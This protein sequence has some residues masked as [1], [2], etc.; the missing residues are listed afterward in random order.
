MSKAKKPIA[1]TMKPDKTV[2]GL[3]VRTMKATGVSS[4]VFDGRVAGVKRRWTIGRVDNWKLKAAQVEARRLATDYDKGI[5]PKAVREAEDAAA[6]AKRIEGQRHTHTV[7]PIWAVYIADRKDAYDPKKRK[8]AWGDRHY[9]MHL[10]LAAPGGEKKKKRGGKGKTIPGPLAPLMKLKLSELTPDTVEHWL[11]SEVK[12]RP[13]NAHQSYRLLSAFVKW[14]HSYKVGKERPYRGIVPADACTD[15]DVVKQVPSSN[16]RK[17]DCLQRDDLRKWFGGVQSIQNPIIRTYLQVLLLI[18]SRRNEL[19][20]LKWS[21]VD[22]ARGEMTIRDKVE[23]LRKIPLTP[24][25]AQLLTALPRST[26]A[27]CKHWVFW[28]E[29]SKTGHIMEPRIAHNDALESAGLPHVSLHGLRRS[30][31]TLSDWDGLDFPAGVIAQIQGHKASGVRET[32]Y[33]RREVDQLRVWHTKFE[34]W[35]LQQGGI[36][37]APLAA[38]RRLGLVNTDGR[39]RAAV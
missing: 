36:K 11:K 13:T 17:G 21:D 27:K 16:T 10:L 20:G 31:A 5:D 37:W 26:K 4:Y 25:V 22:F 24:Y 18:G 7:A 8:P 32:N 38:G 6:E 14:T 3:S 29:D 2:T 23:G 12:R 35:I 9:R 19:T 30:F 33:K 15:V 34:A 1:Y 39:V 28:S